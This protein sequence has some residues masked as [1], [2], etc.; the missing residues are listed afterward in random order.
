MKTPLSRIVIAFKAFVKTLH[1]P[2]L[3]VILAKESDWNI[4]E[5]TLRLDSESGAFEPSLRSE[6]VRALSELHIEYTNQ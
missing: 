1:H 5:E 4:L 2:D 3:V 6:I